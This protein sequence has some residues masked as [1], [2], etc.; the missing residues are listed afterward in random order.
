[1][2]RLIQ[3]IED[4]LHPETGC[5]WDL[6]QTHESLL[7]YL[8]EETYEFMNAVEAGDNTMMKDELGD[9]LLQVLLHSEIARK[10]K[11][12]DL[13]EVAKNLADK[14]I[15][16]HPH[17]FKEGHENISVDEIKE[18]WKTIKEDEKKSLTSKEV[19]RIDSGY[20]S[21]PGLYSAYKI[22][23]KT[24]ELNF[25]WE[26]VHQVVYKVEEEWQELKEELAPPQ[27]NKERVAEEL[28]DFLFSTAQL[29]RHLDL[30]PEEIL[31]KANKKFMDRFQKM[32]KLVE[33]EGHQFE[34]MTQED[35]DY[36]WQQVK[37][38]N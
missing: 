8:L 19:S 23:R 26:D 17:V 20:L 24:R 33:S 10:E 27:F 30:D 7:K 6:D 3:V 22:G 31:R 16:R 35:L 29:A 37:V 36:F 32:E 2:H 12:F 1:M 28:G 13:E 5:P 38:R 11:R 14:M 9:V 21:Y 15:R 34:Q 18:N 4:L 25:D